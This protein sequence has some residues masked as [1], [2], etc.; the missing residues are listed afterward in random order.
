MREAG[1]EDAVDRILDKFVIDAPKRAAAVA[2]ALASGDAAAI[3]REAHAFKSSSASLGA[4]RLAA[5]LQSIEI[6]GKEGRVADAQALA[7]AIQHEV[8]SLLTYLRALRAE[9]PTHG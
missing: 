2:A 8:D 6:A 1:A 3:Q 7:G 9:V 5:H 4:A